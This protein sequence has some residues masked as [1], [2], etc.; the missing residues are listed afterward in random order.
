[1]FINRVSAK[2][3]TKWNMGVLVSFSLYICDL[4]HFHWSHIVNLNFCWHKI[5]FTNPR[6]SSLKMHTIFILFPL[7]LNKNNYHIYVSVFF[8]LKVIS[9]FWIFTRILNHMSSGT[10]YKTLLIES[11]L[12]TFNF[13]RNS[14][15]V[16][17]NLSFLSS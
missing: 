14:D 2:K 16:C 9:D 4:Q 12:C 5:L 6:S 3:Q 10:F 7:L 13:L 1:M 15:S 8:N 17:S 11:H